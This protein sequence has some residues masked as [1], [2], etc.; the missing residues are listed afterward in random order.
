[1]TKR[2]LANTLA[3]AVVFMSGGVTRGAD[4]PA[5]LK[6]TRDELQT[7]QSAVIKEM[8][9]LRRD[10]EK[11]GDLA[12]AKQ[13]LA[14][15]MAAYNAKVAASEKVA[16]AR[17]TADEVQAAGRAV[18]TAEAATDPALAPVQKALAA[19]DD[20]AFDIESELRVA[21][22]VMNELRR[23]A[24]RAPETRTLKATEQTATEAFYA[25]RKAAK[26]VEPAKAARDAAE[27]AHED[28]VTAAVSA[29][30]AGQEQQAKIA[31]LQAKVKAARSAHAE[32]MT[33]FLAAR[34][35]ASRTNPKIAQAR[36]AAEAALTAYRKTVDA[37]AAT[38]RAAVDKA[39]RAL[40]DAAK[41]KLEAD[42]N[43]AHLKKQA[44]AIR[45]QL[46][47]IN[48]EIAALKPKAG[49]L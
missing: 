13:A 10:A 4:D 49:G 12:K 38:E 45:E 22:Y 16:A 15:A 40:D 2:I 19:A 17:K 9:D 5:A 35:N 34:A 42:P 8:A 18:A 14:D 39:Q 7:K 25:A 47:E 37:E 28:A 44:D 48:A 11:S 20:A 46:R 43:Y 6:K 27:K 3:V 29:S 31:A 30:P 23:K 1:M 36:D 21:E 33:E 41:A 26:D 32:R 24:A